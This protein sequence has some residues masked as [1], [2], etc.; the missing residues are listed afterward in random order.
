MKRFVRSA[1][2]SVILGVIALWGGG[3]LK[4]AEPN[5][6][7]KRITIAESIFDEKFPVERIELLLSRQFE[8]ELVRLAKTQGGDPE[9]VARVKKILNGLALD[10][11]GSKTFKEEY[12][13]W[14][15]D[16]LDESELWRYYDFVRSTFGKK[17]AELDD[18]M[19][20][21]LNGTINRL[22]KGRLNNVRV[23]LTEARDRLRPQ[24]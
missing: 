15:A 2:C 8:T 4:G 21:M 10:I 16:Q 3:S 19:Q 22:N 12:A 9:A 24:P 17:V 11:S 7:L 14:L 18:R 5:A 1:F 13:L 20:P 6:V 23:L